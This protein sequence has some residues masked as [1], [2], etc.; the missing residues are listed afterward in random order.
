MKDEWRMILI[1]LDMLTSNPKA[2][3]TFTPPPS[4]LLMQ[5]DPQSSSLLPKKPRLHPVDTAGVDNVWKAS[6]ASSG[7]REGLFRKIPR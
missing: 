1:V 6:L 2:P 5:N 7:K 3:G 4:P